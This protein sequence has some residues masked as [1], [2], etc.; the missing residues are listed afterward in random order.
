MTSSHTSHQAT[1]PRVGYRQSVLDQ[2]KQTLGPVQVLFDDEEVNEIMINGPDDVFYSKKGQERRYRCSLS[3]ATIRTAITLIASLIDKEVGDKNKN[4]LLSSRLP[5]FRIEAILPP[6]AVKG[7]TMC[8]RRHAS[9]VMSIDEYIKTGVIS[10]KYAAVFREAI[11]SRE[12]FLIAGGTGSGKTTLMNSVLQLIDPTE[13]LFVIETVHELQVTSENHVLVE[14]DEDQGV[15]PRRAVRS[16]MRM[17]PKRII[18]G[19]LRGPEA[20]D[21]LDAANTGHPGSGAT[22]HAN[23]AIQALPRLENLL[24]MADMGIP[25]EPLRASIAETVRW[26]FYIQREGAIRKVSQISRLNGF[27]RKTGSYLIEPM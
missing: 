17:A 4:R 11:K 7:P 6:I 19:E 25:Y 9:R 3:S 15:T 10:E 12:N 18:V 27:D 21:W 22:I 23:G 26:L 2:I 5:G 24:L 8:I 14:C 13:R 16:A 20:Y 1:S